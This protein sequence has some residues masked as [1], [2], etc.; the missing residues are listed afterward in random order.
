MHISCYVWAKW[1]CLCWAAQH[2]AQLEVAVIPQNASQACCSQLLVPQGAACSQCHPSTNNSFWL[3]QP[4]SGHN[5][6]HLGFFFICQLWDLPSAHFPLN[7][8][9]LLAISWAS[10]LLS[11]HLQQHIISDSLMSNKIQELH[12][13][14][15]LCYTAWN[16]IGS[17]RISCVLLIFALF[18]R[19]NIN[20][21]RKFHISFIKF[22]VQHRILHISLIGEFQNNCFQILYFWMLEL[23][24]KVYNSVLVTK[25]VC[26]QCL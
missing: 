17:A 18:S 3:L 19:A 13:H 26:K 16:Y 20:Y 7:K 10:C 14:A 8:V 15:D 6:F 24:L 21:S 23:C 1:S 9:C 2:V 22:T 5:Y 25:T 12:G 11:K 4:R